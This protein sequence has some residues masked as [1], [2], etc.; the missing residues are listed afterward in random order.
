LKADGIA[1]HSVSQPRNITK[2][3]ASGT[4]LFR[5]NRKQTVTHNAQLWLRVRKWANKVCELSTNCSFKQSNAR[6]DS[7]HN[8]R[9][10]AQFPLRSLNVSI[11]S[12]NDKL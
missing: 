3:N 12:N 7:R 6:P 10:R 4:E 2:H 8:M 5:A 9:L 11:S 1:I